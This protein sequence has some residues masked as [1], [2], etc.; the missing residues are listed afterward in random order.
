MAA[1][2]IV[3]AAGPVLAQLPGFLDE[4]FDP[5]SGIKGQVD[6]ILVQTNGS[7]VVSA[8]SHSITSLNADG[9]IDETFHPP[10]D[11]ETTPKAL[12]PDGKIVVSFEAKRVDGASVRGFARLNSDG[13]LDGGFEPAFIEG[14][15]EL[16]AVA[17]LDGQGRILIGGS[18]T[19][20][21]GLTRIGRGI[22]RL[23]PDGSVDASFNS[24]AGISGGREVVWTIAPQADG[25][26]VIGGEFLEFDGVPRSGLARLNE[27]G[28]LDTTFDPPA[29]APHWPVT[30][31]ITKAIPQSDGK[32][33]TAGMENPGS[34][35]G[36]G[37]LVRLNADGTVDSGF[38]VGVGSTGPGDRVYTVA[39]QPDGKILIGGEFASINGQPRNRLAR[40][41]EDGALDAAFD[42]GEG[43]SG[44]NQPPSVTVLAPQPDGRVLIGG[45]FTRVNGIPRD[46][47]ARLNADGTLDISFDATGGAIDDTVEVLKALPDGHVLIAGAFSR[48]GGEDR[49]RIARLNPDGTLDVQFDPGTGPIL[50]EAPLQTFVSALAPQTDGKLLVG[51]RFSKFNGTRRTGIARLNADGSVDAAFAPELK[52]EI[53]EWESGDVNAIA[54]LPDGKVMVGGNF[55]V[56]NGAP[57]KC[58]ARLNADGS[59]DPEFDPRAGLTL[60]EIDNISHLAVHS[61]GRIV[62]AGTFTRFT[63]VDR[64]SIARLNPDGS[65]DLEFLPDPGLDRAIT[66]LALKPD[67]K[68]LI[69]GNFTAV[70]RDHIARLNADGSWDDSFEPGTGASGSGFTRVSSIALQA[71]GK[72]LVG[73][74]FTRFN[75]FTRTRIA[76][77]NPDGSVDTQFN[78][79]GGADERIW[80]LD[81]QADGKVLLGGA[82][83]RV[84]GVPRARVARLLGEQPLVEIQLRRP[85][86]WPD[87]SF[88]FEIS[89]EKGRQYVIEASTNLVDWSHAGTVAAESDEFEFRA[90]GHPAPARFYRV[91]P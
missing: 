29:S 80:T 71:D 56:V 88:G 58:I 9:A 51:G 90:G 28:S 13:S 43:P 17:V 61:D 78:P 87:G 14:G 74:E 75:G 84:N 48:V 54:L 69:G 52:S 20:M 6:E 32:I 35:S 83:F 55:N 86:L 23:N 85:R 16:A 33:L 65:L 53:I 79:P 19:N 64:L 30:P 67:G 81:V 76:R 11:W 38:Y 59:L 1:I 2:L 8:V 42:P 82:F 41:N 4:T 31:W 73:G 27:D 18:F 44:A 50:E 22:A 62:M 39:L 68:V 60:F 70:E 15:L 37:G 66:S 34:R 77:L 46:G 26:I 36:D 89:G 49:V 72:I 21:P 7:I 63:G 45:L 5:G 10:T 24:G 3:A 57:R 40:I 12:Q 91:K 25:K 47:I